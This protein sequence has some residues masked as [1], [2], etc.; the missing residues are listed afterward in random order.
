MKL[1]LRNAGKPLRKKR[2]ASTLKDAIVRRAAATKII[3][4][5]QGIMVVT[6]SH[7]KKVTNTDSANPFNREMGQ[8]NQRTN[9][10]Q[11]ETN[12][13]MVIMRRVNKSTASME[14]TLLM[15]MINAHEE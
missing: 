14:G 1:N 9:T 4:G 8:V 12:T 7:T 5:T 15:T 10:P 2:K 3:R 6:E 13:R 11:W